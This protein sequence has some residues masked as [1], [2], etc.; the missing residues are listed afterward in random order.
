MIE[1]QHYTLVSL[2]NMILAFEGQ[3]SLLQVELDEFSCSLNKDVEKFLK[4]K[5][6]IF[7]KQGWSRTHLLYTSYKKQKVLVGYF[8]LAN[9]SFMVKNDAHISKGLKR[10]I[11]KFGQYNEDIK[12]YVVTAPLIG[13]LGKNDEYADLIKGDTLLK[14]ACDEVRKVQE[15]IGGK[16]VYLECEDKEC[17]REFYQS[18]GFVEFGCREL[19]ADEKDDLSGSYLLQM[20]KYLK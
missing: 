5:A 16:F 9:K 10:R 18:N 19:E 13:Q 3:E 12:K 1:N 4:E 7:D 17:L 11:A 20:L 8:T 6:V 2:S 15:I 14:Y